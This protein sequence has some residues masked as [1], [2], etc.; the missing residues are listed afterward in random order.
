MY[1][2]PR[3]R[4]GTAQEPSIPYGARWRAPVCSTQ[5]CGVT[6]STEEPC[7]RC[8]TARAQ[9]CSCGR[10]LTSRFNISSTPEGRP[11]EQSPRV[12]LVL[13]C[14]LLPDSVGHRVVGGA[15]GEGGQLGLFPRE[16]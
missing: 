12:R 5:S 7:A 1:C 13:H 6:S 14:A 4:P 11:N 3:S 15:E 16:P 8:A 2:S 10:S 9:T